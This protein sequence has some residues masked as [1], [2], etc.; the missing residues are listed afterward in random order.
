MRGMGFRDVVLHAAAAGDTAWYPTQVPGLRAEHG[1]L[2]ETIFRAADA[3]GI[4]LILYAY[5]DERYWSA[6]DAGFYDAFTQRTIAVISELWQR[7]GHHRSLSGF[8]LAV[9]FWY[10]ADEA[11]RTL[12]VDHYMRPVSDHVK[13]LR[14]DLRVSC[15]PFVGTLFSYS[16]DHRR[17]DAARF[18]GFWE[19]ILR[20]VPSLDII[21][22]QDG[23]GADE[24]LESGARGRSYGFVRVIF[25]DIARICAQYHRAVWGDLEGFVAVSHGSPPHL[26]RL[27]R[28]MGAAAPYVSNMLAF[29]W[30]YLS[31]GS[32]IG[33]VEFAVNYRRYLRGEPALQRV[34]NGCRYSASPPAESDS[35]GYV[36]TEGDRAG[37]DRCLTWPA[38]GP[39]PVQITVDLG[40]Q[41]PGIEGFAI[42]CRA[43]RDGPVLAWAQVAV[44]A[45]GRQFREA[46]ELRANVTEGWVRTFQGFLARPASARYVR[47]TLAPADGVRLVCSD[48]AV[49]STC[50]HWISMGC[51]YRYATPPDIRFPEGRELTDGDTSPRLYAQVGWRAPSSPVV[52]T[53]DLGS[54]RRVE[55]VEAYFLRIDGVRDVAVSLPA[56]ASVALSLD[57]ESFGEEVPLTPGPASDRAS[58]AFAAD[59]ASGEGRYLRL[60]AEPS[61]NEAAWLMLSEVRAIGGE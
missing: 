30:Q 8:H 25:E 40:R 24:H 56:A 2:L 23:I 48:V 38:G 5:D 46:A 28:Q 10:P 57:G 11:L 59:I 36:L 52:V 44:S 47:F 18:M 41:T 37:P 51:S 9:E 12:W 31:P 53:L 6:T 13:S 60:T 21:I 58:C 42:S 15:A 29:E 19:S 50:P 43:E 1:D 17:Y 7:Y 55:R 33:G 34:S 3:N 14:G 4:Q 61:G 45:D 49:F 32:S 26:S 22:L 39:G 54:V 20:A 27:V 16:D 35:S